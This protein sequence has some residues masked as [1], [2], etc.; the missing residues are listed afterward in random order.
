MQKATVDDLMQSPVRTFRPSDTIGTVREI[1]FGQGYSCA[2]ITDEAGTLQGIVTSTDLIADYD[3]A[4][5]IS[6]I[7]HEKVYTVPRY[8]AT[9]LPAR[10]MRN[11]KLH[12]LVVV[13]D[14]TVV[15]V[16]SSFDLLK[17]VEE[18]AYVAKNRPTESKH[19]KGKRGRAELA[20][21]EARKQG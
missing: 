19:K 2:P 11:H 8:S 9:S 14:Q 5:P 17:L 12:H 3:G 21:A 10:M 7:M 20:A 4:A 18:H 1:L 15:G 13:H 6:S 16:L